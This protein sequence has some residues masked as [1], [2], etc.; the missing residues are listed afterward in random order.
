M[1]ENMDN[2]NKGLVE[3]EEGFKIGDSTI[4]V[5]IDELSK[6]VYAQPNDAENIL[7]AALKSED[8][9]IAH[10]AMCKLIQ[11][12]GTGRYQLEGHPV[13]IPGFPDLEKLKNFVAKTIHDESGV[14]DL[15][16]MLYYEFSH[17]TID[18]V[19]VQ[20]LETALLATQCDETNYLDLDED[21]CKKAK[22][23]LFWLYCQGQYDYYHWNPI[24]IASL[25]DSKKAAEILRYVFLMNGDYNPEF[26]DLKSEG[27]LDEI[28]E[29]AYEIHPTNDNVVRT[30]V[31]RCGTNGYIDKIIEIVRSA[32]KA[33][34]SLIALDLLDEWEYF[35]AY[36]DQEVSP[37]KIEE[38][39]IAFC[40]KDICK[41][42][43]LSLYQFGCAKLLTSMGEYEV[44]QPLL[45][46][47][48]MAKKFASDNRIDIL[49]EVIEIKTQAIVAER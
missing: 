16:Q 37:E 46:D 11:I 29:L 2:S 31:D 15:I 8:E 18:E 1:E 9:D 40:E 47:A 35:F 21:D 20:G 48:E 24:E 42:L 4:Y 32:D 22:L 45:K 19:V 34:A 49:G 12:Y 6:K 36:E 7:L 43:L 5:V 23:I 41:E 17:M 30:W 39:L 28:L 10:Q 14:D 13:N 27:E 44:L 25:K 38:L 3:K 26:Y 33:L